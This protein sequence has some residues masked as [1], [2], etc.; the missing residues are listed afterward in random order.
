MQPAST[1]VVEVK[2][3]GA[4]PEP[5]AKKVTAMQETAFEPAGA[6]AP[7]AV[8]EIKGQIAANL[9][10]IELSTAPP[11]EASAEV[12]A[13]LEGQLVTLERNGERKQFRIT[14]DTK[15]G[16]NN[17]WVY[18]AQD[19]ASEERVAIKVMKQPGADTFD[20]DALVLT[21][22]RGK[23]RNLPGGQGVGRIE[24]LGVRALVMD[25]VEG[26]E[27][28]QFTWQARPMG[29]AVRITLQVLKALQTLHEADFR[30]DDMHPGQVLLNTWQS[31]GSVRVIDMG[32]ARP[33]SDD[34]KVPYGHP[35][36]PPEMRQGSHFSAAGRVNGDLYSAAAVLYFTMMGQHPPLKVT[37]ESVT[38]VPDALAGGAHFRDVLLK[39]FAEDPA[40]RFQTA[41][42]MMQALESFS[43]G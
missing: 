35:Y 29:K 43:R 28:R 11:C 17:S 20:K 31:S 3:A 18:L 6:A 13:K 38:A 19:T 5:I 15:G 42:E 27:L 16:G 32:E 40:E 1:G 33:I 2:D 34:N 12:R 25:P 4:S 21:A 7:V 39:A 23:H 36:V 37:R 24:E 9:P 14:A 8:D 22:I 10:S 26:T 41:R 30:H